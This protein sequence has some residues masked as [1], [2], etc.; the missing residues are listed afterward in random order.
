MACTCVRYY[1]GS[2]GSVSA[3]CPEHG[4]G[5]QHPNRQADKLDPA[6][7]QEYPPFD[8]RNTAYWQDCTVIQELRAAAESTGIADYIRIML[9]SDASMGDVDIAALCAIADILGITVNDEED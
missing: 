9:R 5:N 7:G 4:S 3:D 2:Y 8:V 6:I 1:R